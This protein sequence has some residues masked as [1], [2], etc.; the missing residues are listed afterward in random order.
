M[1]VRQTAANTDRFA[2][3]LDAIAA[4]GASVAPEWLKLLREVAIQSF[5]DH[6]FPTMRQEGWRFTVLVEHFQRRAS[7]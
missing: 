5:A 4:N 3:Q 1:T 2:S 7:H 6:G